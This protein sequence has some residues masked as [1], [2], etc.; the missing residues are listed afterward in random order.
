[1]DDELRPEYDLSQLLEG[2]VRG[3]YADR[4]REGTNCERGFAASNAACQN[5][6]P[7]ICYSRPHLVVVTTHGA[8]HV[9]QAAVGIGDP[10]RL[11]AGVTYVQAEL[12]RGLTII[13]K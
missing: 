10:A 2:G 9:R 12:Y 13:A 8:S 6:E 5:P 3:K 11:A 7:D 1:M 4:Y